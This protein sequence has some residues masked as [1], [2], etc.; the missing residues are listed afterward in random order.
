M[1]LSLHLCDECRVGAQPACTYREYKT[2]NQID[3]CLSV[4]RCHLT[5]SESADFHSSLF[6]IA[7]H[8][9]AGNAYPP[10][11]TVFA[12][13][14][15]TLVL[16][17][18][19]IAG[20]F[21]VLYLELYLSQSACGLHL[22]LCKARATQII[23]QQISQNEKA[24][25]RRSRTLLKTFSSGIQSQLTQSFSSIRRPIATS[26]TQRATLSFAYIDEPS[27]LLERFN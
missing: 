25:S 18:T 15:C 1:M 27:S 6:Y 21:L 22:R 26:S 5:V 9:I 7:V 4:V 8:V 14:R 12:G 20:R 13:T 24:E 11:E 16:G 23:R 17:L 10:C 19:F 3:V 2:C